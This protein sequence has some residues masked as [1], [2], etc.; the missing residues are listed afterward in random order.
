MP[1]F[2]V[3]DRIVFFVHI[4]KTGGTS[5]EEYLCQFGKRGLFCPK[6][7]PIWS[8]CSP[9]HMQAEVHE[10]F[11]PPGL[12]DYGFAIVRHPYSRA[13][14]E[15]KMR[16]ARRLAQG[17][18]RWTFEQ[19]LNKAVHAYRRDN[20]HL[21]NHLRPQNEFL[22]EGIEVFRY[23]QGLDRAAQR[24]AEVLDIPIPAELP[25]AMRGPEVTVPMTRAAMKTLKELYREDFRMLAYD[26]DIER[27]AFENSAAIALARP[28]LSSALFGIFAG[29]R[30]ARE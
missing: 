3:N 22:S 26:D 11:V 29:G 25:H 27:F 14:S 10:R 2:R 12:Y 23:E 7:P 28:G 15:Y 18:P 8:K 9:Q 17:R 24:L 21:D 20:Y 16:N 13:L 4:P 5:I 19:W 30:A 1:L 6:E